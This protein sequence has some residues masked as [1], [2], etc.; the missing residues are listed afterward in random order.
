MKDKL[1]ISIQ[2]WKEPKTKRPDVTW[3]DDRAKQ[4]LWD[5]LMEHFTLPDHFTDA[6]VEKVKDAALRKMAVAFN[7]HKRTTW[8]KYVKGGRRLQ[9]SRGY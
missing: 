3:V 7:N 9:Y 1:P 4:K 8:E 2:E 6:D 5:S